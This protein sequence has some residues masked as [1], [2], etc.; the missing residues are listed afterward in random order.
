MFVGAD[1]L[2]YEVKGEAGRVFNIFTSP[3]VSV[4]AEFNEV[5]PQFQAEDITETVMGSVEVALCTH[6]HNGV[7]RLRMNASDGNVSVVFVPS[8]A[9]KAL[10][11]TRPIAKQLAAVGI[12]LVEE[13]YIC[14]VRRMTCEWL[15]SDEVPSALQLPR[16][17]LGYS[18]V[19]LRS[20]DVQVDVTR[21]AM[22]TLGGSHGI[23]P[24]AVDCATFREWELAERSCR[25]L[26]QGTAPE[27]KRHKWLLMLLM[28]TLPREQQFFFT[29]I[30]IP[31]VKHV[32]RDVHGLLG[33]RAIEPA[34]TRTIDAAARAAA[35]KRAELYADASQT[36]ALGKEPPRRGVDT[37]P[38]SGPTAGGPT[39]S[40]MAVLFGAQGEGA[41]AGQYDEYMVP[42][43]SE[44]D[45]FLYSRFAC[46]SAGGAGEDEAAEGAGEGGEPL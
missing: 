39:P 5:P 28:P 26:L 29:Q 23:P 8:P 12:K 6:S 35:E 9:P 10:E 11:R 36:G 13:R 42:T 7:A 38:A 41:I 3:S 45:R 46:A 25:A 22:V 4:N 30:D 21:N 20:A 15:P 18:R 27:S 2:A 32:Q 43:L 31:L 34:F 17:D 14:N 37:G 1:G 33:Q 16:V 24:S 19:K 44:H 40:R